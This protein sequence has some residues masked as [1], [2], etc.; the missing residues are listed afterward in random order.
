MAESAVAGALRIDLSMGTAQF[1]QGAKKSEAILDRFASKMGVTAGAAAA[2]GTLIGTYLVR[3]LVYARNQVEGAI[4]NVD[5]LNDAAQRIGVS[6]E[7]FS[8]LAYAAKLSGGTIES[9]EVAFRGL[10]NKMDEAA[11]KAS[12]PAAGALAS[13]GVEV[14][15]ADGSL[16]AADDVLLSIA[17][18]FSKME[19]GTRKTAI[20]TDVF[21]KAGT[22]MIQMLN[23]G[24]DGIVEFTEQ[25]KALGLVVDK[26]TAAAMAKWSDDSD[27]LNLQLEG[28]WRTI[29]MNVIPIVNDLSVFARRASLG[30]HGML[31]EAGA[32]IELMKNLVSMDPAIAWT[33]YLTV[34]DQVS[35]ENKRVSKEL[36]DSIAAIANYKPPTRPTTTL[37]NSPAT[38]AV[39]REQQLTVEQA[40]LAVMERQNAAGEYNNSI[41]DVEMQ[42]YAALNESRYLSMDQ[43]AQLDAQLAAGTITTQQY[44]DAI[45]GVGA[46]MDSTFERSAMNVISNLKRIDKMFENV[47]DG[48][49]E[50]WLA[51]GDVMMDTLGAVFGESKEFA[52]ASTIINTAQAIMKAMS[53]L[54]FPAS[55]AAAAAV[56]AMGAAQVAKIA[57]TSKGGGGGGAASAAPAAAAAAAPAQGPSQ[58]MYV[59]GFNRN[60]FFSGDMVSG[61]IEELLQRQRDGAKIVLGP[62]R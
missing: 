32:G 2:A 56:G 1:E 39:G 18:A 24:R 47:S 20:A 13:L 28:L 35:V 60:E 34:L 33:R 41:R 15:K 22:T 6:V 54:P 23:E 52:I 59:Q 46:T 3:G 31:M 19:G 48:S 40:F 7:S 36:E 62:G 42:Q 26:K 10:S 16:R 8:A 9:L 21:G 38:P 5:D 11:Q 29:A 49:A 17:D 55:L 4:K 51:M 43:F 30:L 61:L 57:S 27:K 45:F 44:Q 37:P 14:K 12:G 25:A 50:Q 53:T 58:T